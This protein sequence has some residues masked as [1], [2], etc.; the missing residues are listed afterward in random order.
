MAMTSLSYD[1]PLP[2]KIEVD[3]FNFWT[4]LPSPFAIMS[5][6]LQLA[7]QLSNKRSATE[8]DPIWESVHGKMYYR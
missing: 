7:N 1:Y 2:G 5:L 8:Q 3:C 6:K 4:I